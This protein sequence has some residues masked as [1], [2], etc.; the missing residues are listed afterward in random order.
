MR[1]TAFPMALSIQRTYQRNQNKFPAFTMDTANRKDH[2]NLKKKNQINHKIITSHV[3]IRD[4]RTSKEFLKPEE[5]KKTKQLEFQRK[6]S[7]T[8]KK[9]KIQTVSHV[10]KE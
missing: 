1:P 3:S 7:P 2:S 9:Q 8:K 10:K 6:K 4:Q 5:D